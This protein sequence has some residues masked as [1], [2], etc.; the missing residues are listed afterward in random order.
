MLSSWFTELKPL[1]PVQL[2]FTPISLVPYRKSVWSIHTGELLDGVNTGR[3]F[4]VAMVV[5]VALQP[6]SV[7]VKVY[8]PVAV[9]C[10]FT[11]L[12]LWLVDVKLGPAHVNEVPISVVPVR[13]RVRPSHIGPLF[14]APAV[15]CGFTTT[16]VVAFVEQPLAVAVNV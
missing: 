14:D 1:G 16:V 13:F 5:A 4:T 12:G 9:V 15:G 3:G 10:A 7:A 6:F 8:V 11:M 2:K